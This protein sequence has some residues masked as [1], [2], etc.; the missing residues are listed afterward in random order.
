[1]RKLGSGAFGTVWLAERRSTLATTLF[2]LKFPNG[3]GLDLEAVRKEVRIWS[4]ISGHPNFVPVIEADFFNQ[5][6]VIVSELLSATVTV[7]IELS[8]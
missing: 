2:A 4:R 6:L 8:C 5:H 1:M 3:S 7:P